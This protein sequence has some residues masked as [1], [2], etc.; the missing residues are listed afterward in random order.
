MQCL[1][2]SIFPQIYVS[3]YSICWYVIFVCHNYLNIFYLYI[4]LCVCFQY[5]LESHFA[6]VFLQ[7][8]KITSWNG[9]DMF[10]T[11]RQKMCQNK[12]WLSLDLLWGNSHV[13]R[14]QKISD[15]FREKQTIC[16]CYKMTHSG[17]LNSL[18]IFFFSKDSVW[19]NV[20]RHIW[21][22][23]SCNTVVLTKNVGPIPVSFCLFS[24][25][26]HDTKQYKLI[27]A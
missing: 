10:W 6:F 9:L 1:Y 5:P 13:W 7:R 15:K 17:T 14:R 16:F 22:R 19:I 2:Y 25:F 24:S 20:G 26:P 21:Q 18:P 11:E 23:L 4:D 3:V 8:C 12:P 27:K